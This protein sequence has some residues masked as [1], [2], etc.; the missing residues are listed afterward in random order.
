ME[1]DLEIRLD[2]DQNIM[3]WDTQFTL[4]VKVLVEE[5]L[6]RMGVMGVL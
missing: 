2:A 5:V 3:E 4:I 1:V 6:N